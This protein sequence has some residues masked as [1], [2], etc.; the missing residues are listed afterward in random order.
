MPVR[1]FRWDSTGFPDTNAVAGGHP[2]LPGQFTLY[3]NYPN[4]FN[5]TTTI[6]FDLASQSVVTL[7]VYDILGRQVTTLLDKAR[8]SAGVQLVPFDASHLASGVYF[9]R[10]ETPKLTQTR[11]MVLMK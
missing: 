7:R 1:A 9:Y 10:L 5:P 4:P 11:K 3:Q 6:Q 2:L 8:L